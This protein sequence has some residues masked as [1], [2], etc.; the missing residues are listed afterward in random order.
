MNP[1][2]DILARHRAGAPLWRWSVV[3]F[4]AFR[5]TGCDCVACSARLDISVAFLGGMLRPWAAAWLPV[6]GDA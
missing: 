6:N 2:S 4:A 3:A 1:D 5:D